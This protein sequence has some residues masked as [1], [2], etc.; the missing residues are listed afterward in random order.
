MNHG[1]LQITNTHSSDAMPSSVRS[2]TPRQVNIRSLSNDGSVDI[3]QEVSVVSS[4]AKSPTHRATYSTLPPTISA[5]ATASLNRW[6]SGSRMSDRSSRHQPRPSFTRQS[7]QDA[8][9]LE[10]NRDSMKALADFLMTKEPPPNN[11]MSMPS[12]DEM[13]ILSVK[14]SAFKIFGRQKSKKAKPPKLMRL[15]DSAVAAKTIQGAR[16]I[17]ISI[18]IEHDH[19]DGTPSEPPSRPHSAPRLQSERPDRG[20]VTVLKPVVE[21]RESGSSYLPTESGSDNRNENRDSR[22]ES[23]ITLAAELLGPETTRTLENYY[24]QLNHQQRRAKA[25][26]AKA[27]IKSEQRT[28]SSYV[29]VPP[30]D[31]VRQ[32]SQRSDLRHSGGTVYSTASMTTAPGHSRGV[33]SVS[34]APSSGPSGVRIDLPPRTSSMSKIPLS[35]EAELA[36]AHKLATERAAKE[37]PPRSSVLSVK[38]GN[39]TVASGTSSSQIRPTVFSTGT[40]ET[41][42]GYNFTEIVGTQT[43]KSQTP[44]P[45]S[46]APTKKLPD[47]PEVHIS[48]PSTSPPAKAKAVSD[49]TANRS[50]SLRDKNEEAVATSGQS[51]QERVKARKQRDVAAL[52]GRTDNAATPSISQVVDPQA[53]AVAP[54][55]NSRRRTA[56]Q[57]LA[58]EKTVITVSPIMVVANLAPFTGLV[59]ESDLP[60]PPSKSS[61]RKKQSSSTSTI[62]NVSK[63][64]HTTPRSMNSSYGSDS[65]T[66]PR[67]HS[68]P[69]SSVLESRR[70]ERRAKRNMTLHEKE[71]DARMTKIER[72][73]MMLL[74]ALSGIASS[75]GDLNRLLPRTQ[76]QTQAQLRRTSG[77]LESR[78]VVEGDADWAETARRELR[79]AAASEA[80]AGK[81][82]ES[83][84][85]SAVSPLD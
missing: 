67:S 27:A 60:S 48:R 16:H 38:S 79:S 9:M 18:P 51:R 39:E 31:L 44:R 21:V 50:S 63:G 35:L 80:S 46:S 15:P 14:K 47:L 49:I 52:W 55:R 66:I 70:Q 6:N 4:R 57:E 69:R 65:D 26:E 75:F 59:L 34:T 7:S 54:A 82:K 83:E 62:R 43:P 81:A 11:F 77:L 13:S 22:A 2:E 68:R 56:S 61:L 25:A 19:L 17:A 40:A 74:N 41:A 37:D 3:D 72:D 23:V 76:L 33:S 30:V 85:D 53:T 24:T 71:M 20:A 84:H 45:S 5:G 29:V 42:K 64:T 73:N 1:D 32:D 36:Q 78:E 12:D 10:S 28:H 58:P 8:S